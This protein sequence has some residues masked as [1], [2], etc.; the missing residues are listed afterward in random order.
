MSK[1]FIYLVFVSFLLGTYGCKEKQEEQEEGSVVEG[2]TSK[3]DD[4][5]AESEQKKEN[6]A[7]A[8]DSAPS[9]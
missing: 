3:S 5:P 6:P 9:K 7:F 8:G 1:F 4:P 2:K